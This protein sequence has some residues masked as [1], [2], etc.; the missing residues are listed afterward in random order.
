MTERM[1]K[2]M[3][4]DNE[5]DKLLK[6]INADIKTEDSRYSKELET[7]YIS[8]A[9]SLRPYH[10]LYVKTK[11]MQV[12]PRYKIMINDNGWY[13]QFNPYLGF[14]VGNEFNNSIVCECACSWS[15]THN[16]NYKSFELIK[17]KYYADENFHELLSNW[18]KWFGTFETNF[19]D[20][21]HEAK[22]LDIEIANK[23]FE[24]HKKLTV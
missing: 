21:Y 4:L 8:M 15:N 5:I 3:A 22:A 13:I 14:I 12:Y 7:A 20:A 9:E 6:E 19:I 24:W 1:M 23:N 11:R 16:Y 10:D 18:D 2:L 17:E